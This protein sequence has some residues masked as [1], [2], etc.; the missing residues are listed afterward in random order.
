MLKIYHLYSNGNGV[1][2]LESILIKAKS[3]ESSQNFEEAIQMYLQIDIKLL[4][5]ME[6]L[7]KVIIRIGKL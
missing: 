6:K 4:P 7:Q 5:D 1:M 2:T 3:L